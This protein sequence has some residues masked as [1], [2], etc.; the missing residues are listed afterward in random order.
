MK[1]SDALLGAVEYLFFENAR[2]KASVVPGKT[3]INSNQSNLGKLIFSLKQITAYVNLQLLFAV[4]VNYK[5][6]YQL[7]PRRPRQLSSA[8]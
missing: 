7:R 3:T 1:V 4:I 2:G 5:F 8:A 6:S